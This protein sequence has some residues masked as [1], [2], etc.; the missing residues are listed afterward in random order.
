MKNGPLRSE[1]GAGV[2]YI[3]APDISAIIFKKSCAF[4]PQVVL[5]LMVIAGEIKSQHAFVRL[6]N[7]TPGQTGAARMVTVG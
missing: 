4:I 1:R 6:K 7:E 5:H 3:S 2:S